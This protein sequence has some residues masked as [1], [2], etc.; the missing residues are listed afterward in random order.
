MKRT[1][2]HIVVVFYNRELEP[3][4]YNLTSTPKDYANAFVVTLYTTIFHL[5][6]RLTPLATLTRPDLRY[7]YRA[8][9]PA[10]KKGLI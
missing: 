9:G 10:N 6:P 8:H 7:V 3:N 4:P 5:I 2:T 1:A